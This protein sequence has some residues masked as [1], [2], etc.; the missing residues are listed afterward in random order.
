MEFLS[1]GIKMG[2]VLPADFTTC[3]SDGYSN[4]IFTPRR[5]LNVFQLPSSNL[6]VNKRKLPIVTKRVTTAK[7]P[8][9]SYSDLAFFQMRAFVGGQK[10]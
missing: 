6:D 7:I 4:E 9:V 2:A 1:S 10:F 5:L 3:Q 8:R